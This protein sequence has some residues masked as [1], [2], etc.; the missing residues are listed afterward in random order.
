VGREITS[1][2]A[3]GFALGEDVLGLAENNVD[4]WIDFSSPEG[5]LNLLKKI[6]VPVVIGTTGFTTS[7]LTAIEAYAKTTPVLLS[8]NMSPGM[9]VA[10][11]LLSQLPSPEQFACDVVL[12]ESHHKNK[13]DAPSGTA[14]QI[15]AV[16]KEAG[17]D[18]VETH[19][20]RA[21]AIRGYH[22]V[23]LINDD[24]ELMISHRVENRTVFARGALLAA[25][26][27]LK[28]APVPKVYSMKD[29]FSAE[30][31]EM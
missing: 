13:K 15:L 1:L 21:G 12:E 19:V 16:L 27:L 31:K 10:Q 28:K 23:R 5:C 24:E 14:K 3:G 7:D 22:A 26:F 30:E 29:V 18:R 25:G 2:L 20:T 8:S 11:K 4:V 17:F 6:E 9:N